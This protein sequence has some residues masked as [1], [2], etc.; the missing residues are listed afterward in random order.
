MYQVS[1]SKFF[2]NLDGSSWMDWKFLDGSSWIGSSHPIFFSTY[3]LAARE[4]EIHRLYFKQPCARLKILLVWTILS[5]LE[6]LSLK[7]L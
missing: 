6:S 1:F 5:S 2:K 7:S 4:A 3:Y